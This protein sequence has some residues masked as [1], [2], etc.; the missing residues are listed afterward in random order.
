MDFKLG[1]A[2]SVGILFTALLCGPAAKGQSTAGPGDVPRSGG[3][4]LAD[5]LAEAEAQSSGEET[6]DSPAEETFVDPLA[7]VRASLADPPGSTRITRDSSVWI[8]AK[9][10]RVFVDGFVTLR[11]GPLEMFA[12][13]TGTKEHESI[14][15]T[16]ARASEVHAGLLA[17]GAMQGTTVR[18]RPSYVP[19]TGQRIRVWVMYRDAAGTFHA[20]DARQWLENSSTSMPLETDWVFAGSNEWT[21]PADGKVHYQ[22]DG[23]DMICV[24][25]FGTAMMDLP[26]ESSDSNAELLFNARTAK[27]PPV[28]TP[29]R[30]MLV[31]IPIP[32]DLPPSDAADESP[33]SG[34]VRATV[35]PDEPPN[36]SLLPLRERP[37][38]PANGP[39]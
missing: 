10:K 12:C 30:L 7:K 4:S 39:S 15:A 37:D 6:H 19:A 26:V 11:E 14:V 21:D 23:G 32:S 38:R 20:V 35:D 22:A 33:S 9:H 31:P 17:V 5:S 27:I 36:E 3:G 24:S 8:D 1:R 2:T 13:P 16:L 25:N 28:L 34:P 29:V 18:H